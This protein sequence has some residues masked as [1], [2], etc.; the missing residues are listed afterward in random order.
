M[1]RKIAKMLY[2]RKEIPIATDL[3]LR[4][5]D[6]LIASGELP[7]VRVGKRVLVTHEALTEFCRRGTKAATHRAVENA[8]AGRSGRSRRLR[9]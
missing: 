7:S 6:S 1:K 2:A 5:V 9:S 4:M 8:R 3:S